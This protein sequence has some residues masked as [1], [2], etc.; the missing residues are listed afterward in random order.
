[1]GSSNVMDTF[2]QIVALDRLD[3]ADLVRECDE[4]A[5]L[6]RT[7][8]PFVNAL[9]VTPY[10]D[11]KYLQEKYG[12]IEVA[13]VSDNIDILQLYLENGTLGFFNRSPENNLLVFVRDRRLNFAQPINPEVL[14]ILLKAG[15]RFDGVDMLEKEATLREFIQTSPETLIVLLENGLITSAYRDLFGNTILMLVASALPEKVFYMDR[16]LEDK[17]F[18][19]Q[20]NEVN[21]N[22]ETALFLAYENDNVDIVRML[23][24]IPY[25]S[26]EVQYKTNEGLSVLDIAL[27]RRMPT[28]DLIRR[29]LRTSVIDGKLIENVRSPEVLDILLSKTI[30]YLPKYADSRNA[31]Y[32]EAFLNRTNISLSELE[33]GQEAEIMQILKDS[34][35]TFTDINARDSSGNTLLMKMVEQGNVEEAQH[36]LAE[37]ADPKI[38]ND[39]GKTVLFF[40]QGEDLD[41]FLSLL[42]EYDDVDIDHQD[43]KGNTFLHYSTANRTETRVNTVEKLLE[44]GANPNVEN[45]Q[46]KTPLLTF[47]PYYFLPDFKKIVSGLIKKGADINHT[48]N[49]GVT[50]ASKIIRNYD[51]NTEDKEPFINFLIDSGATVSSEMLNILLFSSVRSGDIKKIRALLAKGADPDAM[52]GDDPILFALEN[53]FLS[54]E[55]TDALEIA[56]LLINEGANIN[57]QDTNRNPLL[58]YIIYTLLDYDSPKNYIRKAIRALLNLGADPDLRNEDGDLV[59]DVESYPDYIQKVLRSK[60]SEGIAPYV[61]QDDLSIDELLEVLEQIEDGADMTPTNRYGETILFQSNLLEDVD[62]LKRFLDAG[63][64]DILDVADNAGSTILGRVFEDPIYEQAQQ[65]LLEYGANVDVEKYQENQINL[66][67]NAANTK[68]IDLLLRRGVDIDTLNQKGNNALQFMLEKNKLDKVQYLIDRGI[69]INGFSEAPKVQ[70]LEAL[71]LLIRNGIDTNLFKLPIQDYKGRPKSILADIFDKAYANTHD[72]DLFITIL[73]YLKLSRE[74]ILAIVREVHGEEG[75][76]NLLFAVDL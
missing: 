71:D 63:G 35:A 74:E 17:I 22:G 12:S 52:V 42:L 67:E 43:A 64:K 60:E 41:T 29:L 66:L 40:I 70:T 28:L 19:N 25:P 58:N 56:Q 75:V 65:F 47:K 3:P 33:R 46:G 45:D 49:R 51:V 21:A 4:I 5:F 62:L 68:V 48:D 30:L 31:R 57:K 26:V 2:K 59:I 76:E 23:L 18:R 44:A 20:I 69:D 1:M 39:E 53:L 8:D 7:S 16:L 73:P 11:L 34:G 27:R 54:E 50:L 6:E 9:C 32:T 13:I 24:D 14:E 72:Y 10:F 37:G 61:N 36:L 38:E 55:L 15:V